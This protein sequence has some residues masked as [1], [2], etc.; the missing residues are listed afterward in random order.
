MIIE[1]LVPAQELPWLLPLRERIKAATRGGRL[2]HALLIHAPQGVGA[3]S[4]AVWISWFALCT[5]QAAAPCG[6]CA[7]CRL[8]RSGNH[9]DFSWITREQDAKQLQ[10]GQIRELGERLALKSYRGGRKVAVIAP[11]DLMNPNAANA[12]LKTLEEPPPETLLILCAARPS[13]LPATVVS[14]CQRLAVP[15][16]KRDVALQ[17]LNT[18]NSEVEDWGELLEFAAGAP[19]RAWRMQ[20]GGFLEFNQEMAASVSALA[21]RTLDIPATADRWARDMLENRLAWIETWITKSVRAEYLQPTPLHS[22]HGIRKIRGLY[23]LLD[24]VRVL[25]L[26][27]STSLNMQLAAE[28]LLLRAQTVLAG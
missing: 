12:L 10:I 18:A 11:A 15:L 6:V 7:D 23:G 16:P 3:E 2:P 28:E 13:R 8:F 17:W 9:P 27:L 20:A 4:L 25:K 24:R 19:L 21:N 5:D 26:E 1:E 14:R 22:Q